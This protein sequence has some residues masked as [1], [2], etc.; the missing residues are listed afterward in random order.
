[1]KS[2]VE[3]TRESLLSVICAISLGFNRIN[4]APLSDELYSIEIDETK[5]EDHQLFL[6]NSKRKQYEVSV[7]QLAALRVSETNKVKEIW[8]DEFK[9]SK[10]FC[11][12]QMSA[13]KLIED[14]VSLATIRLKV[15]GQLK[16][17]NHQVEG[18]DVPIYIDRCYTG[19]LGYMKQVRELVKLKPTMEQKEYYSQ[20]RS[21][22]DSLYSTP[23]KADM[24]TPE[25]IVKLPVFKIII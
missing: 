12:L 24:N 14:N 7:N 18:V 2:V 10:N 23:L 5:A 4:D 16:M 17:R 1:M 13:S 21:L 11:N 9:D 6:V 15:V 19:A 20:L 8:L 22:R 25:N 3:F